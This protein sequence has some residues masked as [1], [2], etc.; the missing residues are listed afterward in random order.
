MAFAPCDPVDRVK[1]SLS[2]SVAGD[3]DLASWKQPAWWLTAGSPDTVGDFGPKDRGI[4]PP[5]STPV[6]GVPLRH[7]YRQ[8]YLSDQEDFRR[9]MM[10]QLEQERMRHEMTF[11]PSSPLTNTSSSNSS[12]G[13]GVSLPDSDAYPPPLH[14]APSPFYF[15]AQPSPQMSFIPATSYS[16]IPLQYKTDPLS[17]SSSR[18]PHTMSVPMTMRAGARD[19]GAGEERDKGE[20]EPTQAVDLPDRGG[21]ET[22][23]EEGSEATEESAGSD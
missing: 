3:H 18:M 10:E 12:G 13:D 8:L 17:Y 19:S 22:T 1:H 7:R 14:L 16:Y 15:S 11:S 9:R 21:G 5:P 23:R 6:T 4:R 2:N 20:D